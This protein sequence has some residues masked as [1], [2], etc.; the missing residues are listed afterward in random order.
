M[1]LR[2]H[3]QGFLLTVVFGLFVP[4]VVIGCKDT[5][6]V[7]SRD[8]AASPKANMFYVPFGFATYKPVTPEII[9]RK[10]FE[11]ISASPEFVAELVLGLNDHSAGSF[12]PLVTRLKVVTL[13]GSVILI[14]N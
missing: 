7:L 10:A 9:E 5:A 12:D 6:S 14:D 4:L 13:D 8:A 2:H 3:P 1:S 11:R